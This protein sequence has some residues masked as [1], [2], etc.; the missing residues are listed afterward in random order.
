MLDKPLPF[1]SE[2]QIWAARAASSMA[3][4]LFDN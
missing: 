1:L 2:Q 3:V 4:G